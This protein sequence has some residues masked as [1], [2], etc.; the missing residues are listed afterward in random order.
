[1]TSRVQLLVDL[2]ADHGEVSIE[3]TERFQILDGSVQSPG[4]GRYSVVYGNSRD[5]RPR[6]SCSCDQSSEVLYVHT[7]NCTEFV[8]D[9]EQLFGC[10]DGCQCRARR[11]RDSKAA[12]PGIRSRAS[13]ETAASLSILVA[14]VM[15]ART[16]ASCLL[17]PCASA[18]RARARSCSG[19]R[20]RV[21]AMH[22]LISEWWQAETSP[23][24]VRGGPSFRAEP[25]PGAT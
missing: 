5:M 7:V 8:G 17:V 21:M 10:E 20:R 25:E 9:D 19:V 23:N 13:S 12:W 24:E 6:G 18:S 16:A 4:S 1:M 15:M 11:I 2:T 22:S 3:S 14:A